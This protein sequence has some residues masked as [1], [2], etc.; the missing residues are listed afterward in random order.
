[1]SEYNKTIFLSY[2]CQNNLKTTRLF[3]DFDTSQFIENDF[4][5]IKQGNRCFYL[6]KKFVS[7]PK[8]LKVI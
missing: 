7:P 3:F 8:I 2:L 4:N 1:M 6:K 5:E